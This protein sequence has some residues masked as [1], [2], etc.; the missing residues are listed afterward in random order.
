[1]SRVSEFC[2]QGTSVMRSILS[3]WLMAATVAGSALVLAQPAAPH[4][5][6]ASAYIVQS[7]GTQS[8]VRIVRGVGGRI[9]HDLPIIHGV[10]AMLTPAQAARLRPHQT[11]LAHSAS[12]STRRRYQTRL[13]PTASSPPS[14]P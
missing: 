2:L 14:R 10:S 7:H 1:M 13:T 11:R 3:R 4:A 5:M 8:A 6:P 12:W 9:T